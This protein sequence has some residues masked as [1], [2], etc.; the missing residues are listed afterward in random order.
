MANYDGWAVADVPYRFQWT[1]PVLISPHDPN[2]IYAT[3]QYVHRST[4]EGASWEKISPDLSVHDPATLV[5][6]GGPIHGDM[7]GTEWYGTIYAFNESPVTKGVLW[8]GSDDGLIHVSRDGGQ[9][10]ENVT[11]KTYGRF[12]RTAVIEPSHYDPGTVYVAANRY[13]QDDFRP[14]L[15]KSTDYGKSWTAINVGIPVGAY[16]RSIREDPERRG[17][18][19]AGTETGVYLSFDDGAR[20]E[21]LQLNLPRSSVRDLRIHGADLIAA[22]HGRAFWAIDDIS[23]LRQLSDSVTGRSAYLFQP[24]PAVRWVSGGGQSLTAGQNPRGGVHIDYYLRSTPTS[25][26]SLEFRD[27]R[28]TVIRTYTSE[29]PPSD[30]A[31]TAAD[32][33][34]QRAREGMRDSLV[35]EPADSVVSARAGTNRF[36][37]NLRYPGAKRI[38]NTLIDEGTLDGPMAPPGNYSVRLIVNRD[39]LVRQFAIASDPRVRTTVAELVRQFEL[40]SQVRDRINDLSDA[41]T[42]LEDIQS[43]LDQRVSQSKDQSFAKQV[44]DAAKA[45]RAKLEAIRSELYEVGCHADQCSLD[46]PVRLYNILLTTALQVQTGDYGPTKQHGDMFTDFSAKVGEQL[47]RLQTVEDSDLAS[48]NKLLLDNRLPQVYVAPR[49]AATP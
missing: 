17:L 35:Y 7:T 5:R 49:K 44:G 26:V 45:L 28:G 13:Q 41:V 18:L 32:S 4:N 37:W 20:W 11:P 36:V 47:R 46:Q 16:T 15:W 34:G 40:A 27:A 19:F 3:S 1:F 14:Y 25:T 48:M 30:T 33:I 22:T 2:T 42:R 38:R 23:L 24:A 6:S 10:W 31:R 39:T 8:A 43:Q 9:H 12:T 29:S 21:P